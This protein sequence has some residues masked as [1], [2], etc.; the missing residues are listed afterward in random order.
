MKRRVYDRQFK[1]EAVKLAYSQDIAVSQTAQALNISAPTLYRW[2]AE[3]ERDKEN[4]F[5][6][7]GSPVINAQYEISKLQKKITYLEQ[8][9]AL[10][11]KFQ[12]FLKRNQA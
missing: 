7:R 1:I 3:W 6:G 8:E 2:I 5:P 12:V 9:R 11:K 10:L 4:A